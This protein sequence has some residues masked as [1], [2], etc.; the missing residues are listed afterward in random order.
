MIKHTSNSKNIFIIGDDQQYIKY[1]IDYLQGALFFVE[2][3]K[4]TLNSIEE[5]LQQDNIHFKPCIFEKNIQ[6]TALD[7]FSGSC[8]FIILLNDGLLGLVKSKDTDHYLINLMR[9]L[10]QY[11]SEY[12][13]YQSTLILYSDMLHQINKTDCSFVINQLLANTYQQPS[14]VDFKQSNI[15]RLELVNNYTRTQTLAKLGKL[16][17]LDLAP[18]IPQVSLWTKTSKMFETH[19]NYFLYLSLF[20]CLIGFAYKFDI[21]IDTTII[22][23]L[24]TILTAAI[25]KLT[26]NPM[27]TVFTPSLKELADI[28]K[29][30][31]NFI[32]KTTDKVDKVGDG[33]TTTIKSTNEHIDKF[34]NSSTQAIQ[35]VAGKSANLLEQGNTQ[36]QNIVETTTKA[37]K[38]TQQEIQQFTLTAKKE[39]KLTT[40]QIRT[41]LSKVDQGLELS[42][43]ELTGLLNTVDH[44][45]Q[46]ISLNLNSSI[47]MFGQEA[48]TT[49][50]LTSAQIQQLFT[51]TQNYMQNLNNQLSQFF[52][53]LSSILN[54]NSQQV[55]TLLSSLDTLVKSTENDINQI[56]IGLSTQIN[57]VGGQTQNTLATLRSSLT[58]VDI[59]LDNFLQQLNQNLNNNLNNF[60]D[61]TYI[62]LHNL[63]DNLKEALMAGKLQPQANATICV[64]V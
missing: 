52:I 50:R 1:V 55:T 29:K 40:K 63:V 39:L 21:N 20:V 33:I 23:A 43:G 34:S 16:E 13:L 27:L 51:C 45:A 14:L 53:N 7:S 61:S 38:S 58:S 2:N 12:E 5:N 46:L 62:E 32:D 36:L 8:K 54:R 47:T 28:P 42:F 17:F 19:R 49:M 11:K 10:Q 57:S 48:R 37:I 26:I 24:F 41:I 4:Y 25:I 64:L 35:I 15:L 6:K 31:N 9:Y 44:N 18:K 60:S 22:F 30:L 3:G 56:S 59:N